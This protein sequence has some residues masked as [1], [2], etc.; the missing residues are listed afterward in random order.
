MVPQ[1][2]KILTRSGINR[3]ARDGMFSF[4]NSMYSHFLKFSDILVADDCNVKWLIFS[5]MLRD[6][7]LEREG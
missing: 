6:E 5:L 4:A 3:R 7:S 2:M 1:A